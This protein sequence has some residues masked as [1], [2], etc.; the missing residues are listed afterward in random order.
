MVH[1]VR[2]GIAAEDARSVAR[3]LIA[4]VLTAASD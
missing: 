4:P 3:R 1:G 2:A